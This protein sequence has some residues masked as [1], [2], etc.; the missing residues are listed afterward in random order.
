MKMTKEQL[1]KLANRLM[2][3]MSDEEYE[4]LLKEFEVY[5]KEIEL[6]ENIE[7]SDE[8]TPMTFPFFYESIGL[9]EDEPGDVL[10]T[11]EVLQNAHDVFDNQVKVKKVI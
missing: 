11:D 2:Y 4:L 6:I 8:I 5:Q 3:D 1:K 7:T 10:T 9:R